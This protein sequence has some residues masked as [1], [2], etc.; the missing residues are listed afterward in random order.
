MPSEATSSESLTGAGGSASKIAPLRGRQADAGC[1]VEASV[2]HLADLSKGLLECPHSM[3][4]GFSQ[5]K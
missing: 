3:V 1:W 5:S 2:P 4:A